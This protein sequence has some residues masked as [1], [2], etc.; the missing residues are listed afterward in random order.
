MKS[1]AGRTI[2]GFVQL[3]VALGLFLFVPA[4]TLDYWQAW[5][6]LFVF[7]SSTA[8]ITVYLWRKDPKLLERRVSAGPGAEKE[9]T[10]KVIQVLASL[11]FAGLFVLSSLDHRFAW[12]YDPNV[13]VFIGDVFV[14]LGLYFVFLVFKENTFTS[15]TI[16]VAPEQRVISSGPY[17]IVR[18]PMYAGA[19][20]M[21]VGVPLA[22]GSC[23]GLLAVIPM[24]AVIIWRLL[25]EEKVLARDLPGYTEYCQ[26][27][28]WRLV[29]FVW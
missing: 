3:I 9:R 17:A 13:L 12:S 27:A 10:Q 11:A 15:A 8:A 25:D 16:E 4:W 19:F 26:R 23:W 1:L 2:R 5:L 6:F 24:I 7:V 14:V 20:V 29:P 22:L 28:R 18:H 21:L